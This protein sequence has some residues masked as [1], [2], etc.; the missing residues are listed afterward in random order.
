MF[1]FDNCN[2]MQEMWV[3]IFDC[4]LSLYSTAQVEKFSTSPLGNS[5]KMSWYMRGSFSPPVHSGRLRLGKLKRILKNF[6]WASP[7][8]I[9]KCLG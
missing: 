2:I 9:Q 4:Q 1:I 6:R 7:K 5:E 8:I 3:L